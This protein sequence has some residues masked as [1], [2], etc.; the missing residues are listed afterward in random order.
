[1][2]I[3]EIFTRTY[4]KYIIN[5]FLCPEIIISTTLRIIY[6]DCNFS[7]LAVLSSGIVSDFA[8]YVINIRTVIR[9]DSDIIRPHSDVT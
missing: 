7:S 8:P 5:D 4:V 3:I 1:M 6:P 9:P 2:F